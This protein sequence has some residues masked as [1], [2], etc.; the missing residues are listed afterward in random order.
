MLYV[1]SSIGV[2]PNL[3]TNG[4][5]IYKRGI[6]HYHQIYLYQC[7]SVSRH[8]RYKSATFSDISKYH[9]SLELRPA[10]LLSSVASHHPIGN[11][12]GSWRGKPFKLFSSLTK[13]A[14]AC[15]LW[16]KVSKV[17]RRKFGRLRDGVQSA[18]TNFVTQCIYAVENCILLLELQAVFARALIN[19]HKFQG[20]GIRRKWFR[21]RVQVTTQAGRLRLGILITWLSLIATR[22]HHAI[23]RKQ[24]S[25]E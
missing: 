11:A 23:S 19:H 8:C 24:R 22:L 18:I 10:Q 4:V 2:D 15:E 21:T 14:C 16:S 7:R 5:T 13:L 12:L 20:K 25:W 17:A 1:H 6:S 3:L 9:T